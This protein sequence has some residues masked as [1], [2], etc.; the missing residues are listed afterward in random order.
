MV[1]RAKRHL[2][3]YSMRDPTAEDIAHL[4][5]RDAEE[6]RQVLIHSEHT[7]SLDSPLDIDPMLSVGESIADEASASPELQLH[8]AEVESLVGEWLA[9]LS[10]KQRMVI[11]GRFGLKGREPLT[12]EELA[13]ALDLTRERVRQIQIE[14]LAQLRNILGRR[15]LSKEVL[16]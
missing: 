10:E 14:S 8:A 16:L 6:V 5:G 7:A 2:E 9:Q 13:M 15:G 3:A 1:L 11:E 12:L 4:V